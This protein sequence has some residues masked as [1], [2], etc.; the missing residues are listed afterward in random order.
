[1]R[2]LAVESSGLVAGAAVVEDGRTLAEYNI[3]Y[4]KTHSQTL[5]PMV[6]A[7]SEMIG[8]DLSTIDAIAV[9]A[10]P[11][12][13]TGLRIGSATAKGLGLA[14]DK[15]I[16]AVPTLEAL[17]YNA[18][19]ISE[20]VC[21]IMDVRRGQVFTAL[22]RFTGGEMETVCEQKIESMRDLIES[23]NERGER[24][25]FLGDGIYVHAELI[26]ERMRVL[27]SFA[28]EHMNAQRAA[29]LGALAL[30]YCAKGRLVSA[31]LHVPD[32]LRV[33]Q[34]ERERAEHGHT[35]W[36]ASEDNETKREKA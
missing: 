1:M 3:N 25:L 15:P 27:W 36:E 5:L 19:G 7:I 31:S 12:S 24:V 4:K 6:N 2:I 20:L 34:A 18:Y 23:L 33:S 21:P 13:F 29:A 11:G 16:A 17:A 14:L 32:Y 26:K 35:K 28:P 30:K 22:Y 9:S 10:G 8:L